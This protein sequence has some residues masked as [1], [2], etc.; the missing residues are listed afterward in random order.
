MDYKQFILGLQNSELTFPFDQ[1]TSVYKVEGKMFAIVDKTGMNIS[2]KNDPAKN[3]MLRE[4][5]SGIKPGYHLNKEH[6]VT[7]DLSVIT[8]REFVQSLI[9]ESYIC[10]VQKLPKKIRIRYPQSAEELL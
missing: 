9:V 1:D 8:D 2:L 5:F 10:V 4:S 7:V 6:W 3:Y